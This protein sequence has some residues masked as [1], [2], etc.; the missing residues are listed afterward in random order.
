MRQT[1]KPENEVGQ[2]IL[3]CARYPCFQAWGGL[4]ELNSLHSSKRVRS[5]LQNEQYRLPLGSHRFAP[6]S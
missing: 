2:F 5:C 4:L 1:Q 3:S 6:Q